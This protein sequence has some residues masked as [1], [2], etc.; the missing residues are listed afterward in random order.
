[1]ATVA[2]FKPSKTPQYL[3]SVNT[4]D[5]EG[6]PDVIVEPDISSVSSVPL[7]YWKR[8]GDAIVEMSQAEKDAIAA[9]ELLAKKA[10][11]DNYGVDM[12]TALTA[13]V[14]VINIRLNA[15]QKITK[16]EMIDALKAEII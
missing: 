1:M 13:L 12:K 10:V 8:V 4:P 15:G 2:I 5:Y 9:T 16:Q 3:Q 6:D 14:K 11:A 7:K